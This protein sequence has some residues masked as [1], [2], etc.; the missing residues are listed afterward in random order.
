[1][2]NLILFLAT[3]IMLVCCITKKKDK[4]P[5]DPGKTTKEYLIA[6]NVHVPDSISDNNYEIFTMRLDGDHKK[7]IT[8][9]RDVAWTYLSTE[10]KVIFISDRDTTKYVRRE[11]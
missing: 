4:N 7:N 3:S 11:A 1:M 6:Y 2:R 8:K 5:D 9:H 10:G